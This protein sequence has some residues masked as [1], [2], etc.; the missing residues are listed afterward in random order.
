MAKRSFDIFLSLVAGI[1]FLI[2]CVII[3]V[4]VKISSPGPVLYVSQRVGRHGVPFN[5][6]KFRS[7]RIDT[8]VLATDKLGDPNAYLTSIGKCLRQTSLDE[9]PQI[10]SVL[11]GH[12]SF[13][14]PRPALFNQDDLITRRH[15][16]GLANLRPGI[17]GWAQINGRDDISLDE[18]IRLDSEYIEWQSLWFDIKIMLLTIL[19][20]FGRKGI[21]H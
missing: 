17:T 6:A 15:R 5:M 14:G 16:V 10:I 21:S 20:V 1:I 3:G 19:A 8:P 18:K 2:P 12:M 7:M 4:L 13:V 11:Q 9:L